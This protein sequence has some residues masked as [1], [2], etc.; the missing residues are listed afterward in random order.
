MMQLAFDLAPPPL[1]RR[2]DPATSHAAAESARELAQRH[3]R[4]IV[5]AL[6]THG[7][8][9][10][11]GIGRVTGLNGVAVARRMS[12]LD[13]MSRV[14]ATGRTVQSNAGRAEREW[15]AAL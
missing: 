11:D 12:E 3:H 4:M 7:P 5:D 8:M 9:G 10:K 6:R 2:T 15:R 14:Q 1:A 13:V